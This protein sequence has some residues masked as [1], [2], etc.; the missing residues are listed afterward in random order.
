MSK[1][2]LLAESPEIYDTLQSWGSYFVDNL[3]VDKRVNHLA[4][5]LLTIV[6]VGTGAAVVSLAFPPLV[7]LLPLGGL[8]F[9]GGCLLTHAFVIYCIHRF[10]T[11]SRTARLR[12]AGSR[13]QITSNG[14]RRC[15]FRC[16]RNS[17]TWALRMLFGN[18]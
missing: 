14:P 15:R 4:L 12:C 18:N 11:H 1:P 13:S 17:I 7:A 10:G 2:H 9:G 8:L 16:P 5:S 3:F 6:S